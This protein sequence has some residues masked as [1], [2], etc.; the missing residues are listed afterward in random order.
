MY[1]CKFFSPR[2]PI[3]NWSGTSNSA[4]C[5]PN[6]NF[7]YF[8][9]PVSATTT[10]TTHLLLTCIAFAFWRVACWRRRRRRW[11]LRL[12]WFLLLYFQ[13]SETFVVFTLTFRH[14]HTT[15]TNIH[16]LTHN[17]FSCF[18]HSTF[19]FLLAWYFLHLLGLYFPS[20]ILIRT[21]FAIIWLVIKY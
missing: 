16:T 1:V 4:L 7:H 12:R 6:I 8:I 14:T 3:A 21:K 5:L 20:H 2:T 15:N 17:F 10:T 18:S 9:L 13:R 19:D 11:C